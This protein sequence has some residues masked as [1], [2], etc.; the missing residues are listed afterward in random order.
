MCII[1]NETFG[2]HNTL[3]NYAFSETRQLNDVGNYIQVITWVNIFIII[4]V[5][6]YYISF[7]ASH[8][9]E[10]IKVFT[11][12]TVVWCFRDPDDDFLDQIACS[13][14][15]S[16]SSFCVSLSGWSIPS[17]TNKLW[18]GRSTGHLGGFLHA[19]TWGMLWGRWSVARPS[20]MEVEPGWR[21][22]TVEACRG[23]KKFYK[24]SFV[25]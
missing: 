16:A 18:S 3:G 22:T 6:L 12:E 17:L 15:L 23:L 10:I 24:N 7:N 13:I 9:H 19:M 1:W 4:V 5:P 21:I 25:F 8:I 2:S 20:H 14:T 11:C